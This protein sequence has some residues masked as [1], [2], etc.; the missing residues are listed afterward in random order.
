HSPVAR[1]A[2]VVGQMT[3]PQWISAG[4]LMQP[5]SAIT[6]SQRRIPPSYVDQP[7]TC[8]IFAAYSAIARS[9]ENLPA[10]ATLMIDD[11]IHL[12]GVRHAAATCFWQS[13]YARKSAH[14]RNGS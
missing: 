2:L 6:T 1:H 7:P 13:T 14:T 5:A 9:L 8:Q 10:R 11:W 3:L 12:P 4:S